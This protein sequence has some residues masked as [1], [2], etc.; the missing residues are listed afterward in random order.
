[1]EITTKRKQ[2]ERHVK[3]GKTREALRL[4]ASFPELGAHKADI[5]RGWAALNHADFYRQIG[6]D[7]EGLVKIGMQAIRNRYNFT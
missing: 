1:M 4:A 5:E 2:L 7:P 3:D 6:K